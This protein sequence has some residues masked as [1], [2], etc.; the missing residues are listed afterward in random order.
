[1]IETR[2]QL[3]DSPLRASVIAAKGGGLVLVAVSAWSLRTG[4]HLSATYPVAA[5]AMFAAF[6]GVAIGYLRDLHPFATFGPAN[7]IT[8]VRLTLVALVAGLV[9]E[10]AT[11]GTASMAVAAAACAVAL[12][13]VDG[14]LARRQGMA[15]AFG[16]RFD[17]EID[18]LLI[19]VLSALAYHGGKAGVWVLAS[20]LMRYAFV[21]AARVLPWM[22]APLPPSLRRKTVCVVQVLALIAV[23]APALGPSRSSLVAAVALAAL[24]YSF[25]IDTLWLAR[26]AP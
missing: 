20:G 1:M 2:W 19:L 10:A 22:N 14:W 9:G 26:Q 11:P 4:L 6:M 7:Q 15:S 8:T 24:S 23:V 18:A 25:F 17:M 13:G 16:A 12:D 3:P 21:G 5:T